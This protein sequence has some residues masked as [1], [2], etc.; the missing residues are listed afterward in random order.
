MK[1]MRDDGGRGG[2]GPPLVSA[3]AGAGAGAHA[4]THARLHTTRPHT[5]AAG[6]DHCMQHPCS[7]SWRASEGAVC[8]A[9]ART[10]ARMHACK[11][12]STYARTHAR[13]AHRAAATPALNQLKASPSSPFFSSPLL[14]R[15]VPVQSAVPHRQVA[16]VLQRYQALWGVQAGHILQGVSLRAPGGEREGGGASQ[17]LELG[18]AR[19]CKA[20]VLQHSVLTDRAPTPLARSP[21]HTL[22]N[23][24]WWVVGRAWQGVDEVHLRLGVHSRAR[25]WGCGVSER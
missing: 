23:M 13:P 3:S 25:G 24:P 5:H 18:A 8:P 4:R 10:R 22:L 16:A 19:V 7:I 20:F 2:G 17:T 15:A 9:H 21:F 6:Y 1:V 14:A 11:H 12:A